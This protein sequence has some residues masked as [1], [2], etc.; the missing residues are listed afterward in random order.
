MVA[1]ALL[2]VLLPA[3][4]F[5]A[6]VL[7]RVFESSTGPQTAPASVPAS[8]SPA[9]SVPNLVGL[10]EQDAISQLNSASLLLGTVT[11]ASSGTVP[12][13]IVMATAPAAGSLV[14]AGTT[15]DLTLSSGPAA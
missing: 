1:V 9:A 10:T 2:A 13:S 7:F 8:A 14:P 11:T 3:I 6:I 15:V 5:G 4:W 12:K